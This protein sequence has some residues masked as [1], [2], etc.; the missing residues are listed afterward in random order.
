MLTRPD[1][2][3]ICE[4]QAHN[5]CSTNTSWQ[6]CA[7]EHSLLRKIGRTPYSHNYFGNVCSNFCE[8]PLD[9]KSK[10]QGHCNYRLLTCVSVNSPNPCKHSIES[11][12]LHHSEDMHALLPRVVQQTVPT[13]YI[14]QA[15]QLP[16]RRNTVRRACSTCF[17]LRESKSIGE[18]VALFCGE[19]GWG[20]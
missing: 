7:S 1:L 6:Y 10:C 2:R 4:A 12:C 3:Y 14:H 17:T 11:N 13:S 9:G 5:R 15:A 18:N 8:D 20:P 19:E 16:N